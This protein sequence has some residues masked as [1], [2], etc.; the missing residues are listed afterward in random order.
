MKGSEVLLEL[1]DCLPAC[2]LGFKVKEK[3]YEV[4]SKSIN[5]E[6]NDDG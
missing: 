2:L 6:L 5:I 4:M 1:T 3:G